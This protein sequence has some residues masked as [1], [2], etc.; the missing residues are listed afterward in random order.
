MWNQT[1]CQQVVQ[2]TSAAWGEFVRRHVPNQVGSLNAAV[3]RR[4]LI[5]D[6]MTG[7]IY[8]AVGTGC[9]KSRDE[10]DE[11]QAADAKLAPSERRCSMRWAHTDRHK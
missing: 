6:K 5:V 11:G 3:A 4:I 7:M 1:V 8:Q 9:Q 2:K 10:D